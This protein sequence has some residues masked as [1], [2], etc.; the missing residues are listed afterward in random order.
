MASGAQHNG[1]RQSSL[2]ILMQWFTIVFGFAVA[3]PSIIRFPDASDGRARSALSSKGGQSTG[4]HRNRFD[5]QE[6]QKM[7]HRLSTY[8]IEELPV[9]EDEAR[10][11]CHD[12]EAA[13]RSSDS[14]AF[15]EQFS[16]PACLHRVSA[17]L[18]LENRERIESMLSSADPF[19][20]IT[21]GILQ[22]AGSGG[23]FKLVRFERSDGDIRPMFRRISVNPADVTYCEL[24]LRRCNGHVRVVDFVAG[25][26][27]Q[28][29]SQVIGDGARRMIRVLDDSVQVYAN[30]PEVVF[31]ERIADVEKLVREESY[32]R[33]LNVI[34][35]IPAQWK[36]DKVVM[37]TKCRAAEKV[38]EREFKQA[39]DELEKVFPNER[40]TL[41]MKLRLCRRLRQHAEVIACVRQ[42][43]EDIQDPY[44]SVFMVPALLELGRRE[45]A[46]VV[47]RVVKDAADH[48]SEPWRLELEMSMSAMDHSRTERVVAE[49]EK[50][51]PDIDLNLSSLPG[52]DEFADSERGS[53]CLARRAGF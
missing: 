7:S 36:T 49:M 2:R 47:I 24:V 11:F 5:A 33:A 16:Q 35:D 23:D 17:T 22:A 50:R 38:G 8:A 29:M 6:R 19:G 48:R 28:T 34:S 44:L 4:L 3:V 15:T 26:D 53:A 18:P 31:A 46:E 37:F 13:A 32:V 51:F 39:F 45:E 27:G 40:A 21:S 41:Q 43:M 25:S 52:F 1:Y 12:L 14:V 30:D 20:P 10:Q 9:S 42:L